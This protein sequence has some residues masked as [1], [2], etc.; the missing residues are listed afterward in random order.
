MTSFPSA[1]GLYVPEILM[2]SF[3][4]KFPN[5]KSGYPGYWWFTYGVR[6]VGAL[7]KSL[8]ARGFI[9]INKDTGKYMT[10]T[11]GESEIRENE[12]VAYT[13]RNSKLSNFTAWD[14]NLI[15]GEGDKT[16]FM[17]KFC[18]ITG[19]IPPLSEQEINEIAVN[20]VNKKS[21][22]KR[23]PLTEIKNLYDS[24][25]GFKDGNIYWRKGEQYRK[26][27]DLYTAIDYYDKARFNGY[28]APALYNSYLI[29][30]RKLKEYNEELEI[31]NEVIMRCINQ[32]RMFLGLEPVDH[33]IEVEGIG[34]ESY[35]E[36]RMKVK[37]LIS[38]SI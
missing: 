24:S 18:E 31:L 3:C 26:A 32:N 22:S 28:D 19:E 11:L 21:I 37:D 34:I 1:R 14:F 36:R 23:L 9:K 12:Y 29:S 27:G 7:L 2:L 33:E 15:L 6:D 25:A 10:T 30:F 17:T 35:I 20:R 8:E 16:N 38:K 4:G 5:P 13:H